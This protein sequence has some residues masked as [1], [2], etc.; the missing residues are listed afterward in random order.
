MTTRG[1]GYARRRAVEL[2]ELE[3][4]HG[5]RLSGDVLAVASSE[6]ISEATVRRAAR[7]LGVVRDTSHSRGGQASWSL[8]NHPAYQPGG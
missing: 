6:G 7:E 4:R 2:I 1:A 5:P 3:L 8:P